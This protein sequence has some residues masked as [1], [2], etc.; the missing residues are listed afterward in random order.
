M[1][2]KNTRKS[3]LTLAAVAIASLALS[4]TA[5]NAAEIF[6]ED[7]ES[8]GIADGTFDGGSGWT[9]SSFTLD[10]NTKGNLLNPT[11]T[12]SGWLNPVPPALGEIFAT[13]HSGGTGTSDL[14]DTFDA[15]TTYT[16]TFT[17]F[18]RDDQTGDANACL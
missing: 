8:T 13:L 6:S 11:G 3:V 9:G 10:S 14:V 17:H 5:A 18:A 16:L 1:L 4:T 15:N 7:W 12:G 2:T